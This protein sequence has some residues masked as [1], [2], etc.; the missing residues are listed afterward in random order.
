MTGVELNKD[1]SS[2]SLEL[3]VLILFRIACAMS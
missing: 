1:C 3:V 2:S